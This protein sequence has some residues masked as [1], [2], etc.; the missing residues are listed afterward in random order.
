[1]LTPAELELVHKAALHLTLE[2]ALMGETY[3][4]D[5]AGGSRSN[6][7]DGRSYFMN[8]RGLW[9]G[10]AGEFVRWGGDERAH[11]I[12]MSRIVDHGRAFRHQ[13]DQ[14]R[15]LDTAGRELRRQQWFYRTDGRS[16]EEVSAHNDELRPLMDAN[17]WARRALLDEILAIPEGLF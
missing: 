6:Q 16:D 15:E 14:L 3:G 17:Y 5:G 9:I 10:Q 11:F 8:K 2:D 7:A 1:M 4:Y 13:V 12:P